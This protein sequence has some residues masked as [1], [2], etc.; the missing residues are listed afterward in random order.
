MRTFPLASS[1]VSG[2]PD[3]AL[4]L[5]AELKLV[6]HNRAFLDFT[7]LRPRALKAALDAKAS[8]LE[9]FGPPDALSQARQCLNERRVIRMHEVELPL[10]NGEFRVAILSFIPVSEK[11]GSAP[12]G[13]IY[14]IRDVSAE[15][16]MQLH[17]KE[18][19]ANERARSHELENRVDER[20]KEL[21]VALQEV[22]RL[23]RTDPLTGALNRRAFREYA[24]HAL[25]MS[26]R[27]ERVLGL[28]MCDLDHFK[29]VNDTYGHHAGD[30]MLVAVV[31][32]LSG[33]LRT[34]DK[35]GRFGGEEFA[36]LLSETTTEHVLEVAHRCSVAVRALPKGELI[37]GATGRQTISVGCAYYPMHGE[38]IGDLVAAADRAVYHAKANGRDRVDMCTH[39]M[40]STKEDGAAARPRALIVHQREDKAQHL[41]KALSAV[42]EV[43]TAPSGV[44]STELTENHPFEV[45]VSAEV[46]GDATGREI[47]RGSLKVLPDALRILVMDREDLTVTS[48]GELSGDVDCFFTESERPERLLDVIEETLL[49]REILRRRLLAVG[50]R[51]TATAKSEASPIDLDEVLVAETLP[52]AFQPIVDVIGGSVRGFEALCRPDPNRFDGP[53]AI[54]E[55]ARSAGKSWQLGRLARRSIALHMKELPTD[56]LMYINLAPA[57]LDDPELLAGDPHLLPWASRVVFEVTERSGVLDFQRFREH[58]A[59]LRAHGFRFAVD[60]LGSSYVSLSS[61][62]RLRPDAIKI[63][64]GLVRDVHRHPDQANLIQRIID[65]TIDAGIE[66]IAEGVENKAELRAIAGLGCHLMQGFYFARPG[67]IVLPASLDTPGTV[68]LV[69]QVFRAGLSGDQARQP[70][71]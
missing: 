55:A 31:K 3:P 47:L 64:M 59:Q 36:I 21:K 23:A 49:R 41:A 65:F 68:D 14:T 60:D 5:D 17:Y 70:L 27:Y 54:F 37:S 24:D 26:Q 12:S 38:T 13:I 1:I 22:T 69:E 56:A 10:P 4:L 42:Y 51:P 19:I 29:K 20:T 43:T 58:V 57:D 53:N 6:V 46:V 48:R 63:D 61:I 40:S 30:V 33:V 9:V 45:L 67:P 71:R 44:K 2:L 16:R 50:L 7:E 25:L 28:L 39:E 8:P 52:F 62:E 66:A 11:E 32:A 18:L 15:A 34:T 35:I